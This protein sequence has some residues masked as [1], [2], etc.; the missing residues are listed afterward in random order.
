MKRVIYRTYEIDEAT[1]AETR[2]ANVAI[3][4]FVIYLLRYLPAFVVRLLLRRAE[5][6][7]DSIKIEG[8]SLREALCIGYDILTDFAAEQEYSTLSSLIFEIDAH[9]STYHI[10]QPLT[11]E[12]LQVFPP[13]VRE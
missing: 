8:I 5:I 1:G 12:E 4:L 6:E 11:E 7:M 13:E 10:L 2:T 9:V 3:P